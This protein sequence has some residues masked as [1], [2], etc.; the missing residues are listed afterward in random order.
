M[1][2]FRLCCDKIYHIVDSMTLNLITGNRGKSMTNTSEKY[3]QIFINL[4]S[5]AHSRTGIIIDNL[6]LYSYRRWNTFNKIHFRLIHSTEELTH[7]TTKRLH[8]S[9]LPLGI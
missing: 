7:I 5:C 1:G 6:L 3:F 8:V 4:G 2:S 9:S